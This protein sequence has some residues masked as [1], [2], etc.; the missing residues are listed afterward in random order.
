MV[1]AGGELYN[2][3]IWWESVTTS[4]IAGLYQVVAGHTQVRTDTGMLSMC[5]PVWAAYDLFS[6]GVCLPQFQSASILV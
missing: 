2:A 6:R 1:T 4:N 5:H 3:S